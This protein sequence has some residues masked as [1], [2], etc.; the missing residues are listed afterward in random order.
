M[1]PDLGRYAFE[2]LSSYAVT[3]GIL[4]AVVA[5]Y[6]WHDARTRAALRDAE[7]RRQA[8]DG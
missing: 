5:L 8:R 7:R 2:V 6:L 3:L 4:A 1:M